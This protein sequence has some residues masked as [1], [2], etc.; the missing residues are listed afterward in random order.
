MGARMAEFNETR[1]TSS[2]PH[3]SK[4]YSEFS[5]F[6]DKIFHRIFF[7][8]IARVI[9]SL[10]IP[11]GARVLEVGVGTGL[12]LS[13]YPTHCDVVGVDLAQDM[14][15]RAALKVDAHG[16]RHITLQRMDALNLEFPDDSFD[17]VTAYHVVSVVPDAARMM[18]E[19]RRVCRPGGTLVIINHFRTERRI[20]GPLVEIL[21]PLTRKLGWSTKLK[22]V[23]VFDGVPLA[24]EQRY[25][26]SP[27]SLFT[28]VVARNQSELAAVG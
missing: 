5:R 4:I 3:E 15:D 28:V 23:D 16:W 14:L 7:P 13:A 6:Y 11:P 20:I 24:I 18:D 12:S 17:F 8:R 10:R 19:M 22:L 2:D 1:S 25:K 27:R 21:D 9:G 26:T